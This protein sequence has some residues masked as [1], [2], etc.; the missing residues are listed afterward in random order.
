MKT[1]AR[2]AV[3]AGA[4][5]L[6]AGIGLDRALLAQPEIKRSI[7]LRA[8]VPTGVQYETVMAVAEIP[9]GGTSGP[10]RHPGFEIG[11][12]IQGSLV[13]E[14]EGRPTVTLKAGDSFKN[15]AVHNGTN[16]GNV[17]AKILAIYVIEKGKPVSEPVK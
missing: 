1:S 12:L 5:G 9:P 10:H 17:P 15:D 7:L 11:Y 2:Y 8:D 13:L 4:I 6:A 14:H 3:L 16:K